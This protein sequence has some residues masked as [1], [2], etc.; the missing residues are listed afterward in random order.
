[1]NTQG[2]LTD[3]RYAMQ[4]LFKSKYAGTDEVQRALDALVPALAVFIG[5]L[6][7]NRPRSEGNRQQP[8][9]LLAHLQGRG[10]EAKVHYP[11]PLHLQPGFKALGYQ[12]GDFPRAEAFAK[13][14][15]SLP[16][17]QFL[18]SEQISFVIE[19]IRGFYR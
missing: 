12:A 13:S 6:P 7:W 14:H 11:I 9:E 10:I 16:V 8:A 19:A 5:L 17:H 15:C 18:T 2:M 3:V 4:Q 1:M